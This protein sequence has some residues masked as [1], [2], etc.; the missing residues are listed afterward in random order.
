MQ[1]TAAA[2]CSCA[3]MY[4]LYSV[5]IAGG[6]REPLPLVELEQEPRERVRSIELLCDSELPNK[7]R[8]A[9]KDMVL[10]TFA[11]DL[12]GDE[13]GRSGLIAD[14]GGAEKY[15]QMMK[16]VRAVYT[17]QRHKNITEVLT[18][19]IALFPDVQEA[20]GGSSSSAVRAGQGADASDNE[21]TEEVLNLL[22]G[23]IRDGLKSVLQISVKC[24][25][26]EDTCDSAHKCLDALDKAMCLSSNEKLKKHLL[27]LVNEYYGM[28]LQVAM[29]AKK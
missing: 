3:A 26:Q 13:S 20:G 23:I 15:V 1:W 12:E 18:S 17:R 29:P 22:I 8:K 7:L 28:S 27:K 21:G 19:W 25:I 16:K 4:G 24:L 10:T 14:D 9:V 11:Y 5:A 2:G 6:R